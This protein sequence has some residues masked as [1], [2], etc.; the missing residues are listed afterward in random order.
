MC[1]QSSAL[2]KSFVDE[3]VENAF[4]RMEMMRSF[5]NKL[6]HDD[7]C[8]Y[9]VICIHKYAQNE[10]EKTLN[11]NDFFFFLSA[12][13]AASIPMHKLFFATIFYDFFFAS[14]ENIFRVLWLFPI[15]AFEFEMASLY[16]GC[17]CVC[18]M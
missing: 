5:T 14:N 9:S 17:V 8:A 16:V 7:G 10:R 1:I 11:F 2:A 13:I 4:D 18:V 3:N 6:E 12:R 15:C